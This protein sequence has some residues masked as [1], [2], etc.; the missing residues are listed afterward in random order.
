MGI[1]EYYSIGRSTLIAAL[2]KILWVFPLKN[3]RVFFQSYEDANGFTDNPKYLCEY[4]HNRYGN[5]L[6]Y[7]FAVNEKEDNCDVDYVKKVRRL[8]LKWLYY[9]NTS[10]IVVI[11]VRMHVWLRRRKGQLVINTWHA[12]GAYKRTGSHANPVF[13]RW[14]E[15]K[16]RKYINLFIS[17]SR[18]FTKYNI[19]EGM[20]YRGEILN[21][22]MPRNDILFSEKQIER[23][24]EK[25]RKKYGTGDAFCILFAPTF[26]GN[27]QTQKIETLPPLEKVKEIL[28]A[29]LHKRVV[30]FVRKHHHD[31][32][33]YD[34]P[35]LTIDVSSYPDIQELLCCSDML[36]TD[37]S[38]TMWDFA[39]LGRPCFLYVPDLAEYK[40]QRD[41]FTPIEQW[42]G[43]ICHNDEELLKNIAEID[44]DHA[45]A[46]A[47]RYLK[48]AGSYESGDASRKIAEYIYN[49]VF[50]NEDGKTV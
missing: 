28:S 40:N 1:H 12:G 4:L 22:G 38:S 9:I 31:V 33:R 23:F 50:G 35:E 2:S 6:E 46:D 21:C 25:L 36:I 8:S 29:K 37:Y 7:V 45:K 43:I 26:R 32:N 42:P 44:F 15:D 5:T 10:K 39:L 48:N 11:N 14:A 27:G 16:I 17:S 18:I 47:I 19:K 13:G 24:A 30:V 3:N 41:F 49:F 34:I 20:D